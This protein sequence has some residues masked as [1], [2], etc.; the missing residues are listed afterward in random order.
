MSSSTSK[1]P[2]NVSIQN[3]ASEAADAI[4][5]IADALPLENVSPD[6]VAQIGTRVSIEVMTIAASIL[7]RNPD[8]FPGFDG[9]ALKQSI[10]YEQAM[11]PLAAVVTDFG[12]RILRN[13]RK[14]RSSGST[15]TLALYQILKGHVRLKADDPLATELRK[16]EKLLTTYRRRRATSVTQQEMAAEKKTR[17]KAKIAAA[18]E[19]AMADLKA[20][21]DAAKRDAGIAPTPDPT[22][23]VAAPAAPPVTVS[24]H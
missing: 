24:T 21:A 23:V 13:V 11:A 15:Q 19:A 6:P 4:Q 10:V 12:E 2:K 22:P 20:Q 14:R 8:R 18:K 17:R 5:K 7:T 16:M 3:H 1:Q 9:E